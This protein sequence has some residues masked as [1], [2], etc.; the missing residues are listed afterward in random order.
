MVE[1]STRRRCNENPSITAEAVESAEN[2]SKRM[3]RVE[4]ALC[5]QQPDVDE[6]ALRQL[7]EYVLSAQNVA[8]ATISVALVDSATMR[9]LNQQYLQHDYD[10]DVLSFPFSEP[11]QPLDGEVIISPHYAAQACHEFGTSLHQEIGIY[12]IH[13]LLHLCGYRDDQEPDRQQMHDR[14][15]ELWEQWVGSGM[16]LT[17][18]KENTHEG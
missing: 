13:G 14:Q 2:A 16:T 15:S 10:T 1:S 12:L 9:Q 17:T 3:Y 7:A 11:D 6:A 8:D 4:V 18:S 5:L